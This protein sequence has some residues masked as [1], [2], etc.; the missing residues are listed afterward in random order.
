M[1]IRLV[2]LSASTF[3][4]VR[5]HYTK[6]LHFQILIFFIFYYYLL[7]SNLLPLPTSILLDQFLIVLYNGLK[8]TFMWERH[9]FWHS[10]GMENSGKKTNRVSW[11]KMH[12]FEKN[13]GI[14][15]LL[16]LFTP[17]N[18]RQNKAL[19]KPLLFTPGNS[20]KLC[21]TAW[22]IQG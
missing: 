18:P 3:W 11:L 6:A 17:G 5:Y 15:K 2:I 20:A 9:D 16:I 1:V 8:K 19:V 13:P 21:W 4:T 10:I 22:K 7:Q 12:Y 14:F